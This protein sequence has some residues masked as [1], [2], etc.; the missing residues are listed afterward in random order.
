MTTTTLLIL[1]ASGDLTSR[2]LLPALGQLLA[3]EPQ[4]AITLLGAG[5]DDWSTEQWQQTVQSA[6]AQVD[7]EDALDRVSGKTY[8]QV[9]VTDPVSLRELFAGISSPY[10]LYFALPPAITRK[11]CELLT[12]ISLP[13]DTLL[14]L[15][16]PFGDDVESAQSL[17]QLLLTLVPEEQIFRVDHFLGRSTLLNVLGVRL[18]NR[19][20]AP[21]WNAE[22]VE[23][24]E[25]RFD[26]SLALEGRAWYYDHSGALV[27]MIQSHLLQVLSLVALEPP[28]SLDAV[29][30]RSAKLAAL[31]ATR[32]WQDDPAVASRRGRYTSGTVADRDIVSYVDEPGIDP[33]RNTETF[34]EVICEVQTERWAGV[35]FRLRSG[36]ALTTKRSEVSLLFRPVRHLA[37]G[38]SGSAPHGGRLTFALGPD[39]LQ[40]DLNMTGHADPFELRPGTLRADL[41]DGELLAY[42][43]VLA[44]FFDR[45]VTLSVSASA[46]EEGWRIIQPIRD[47]WTQGAVP[48]EDYPAGSEGPEPR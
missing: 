19:V 18:A 22:Q 7:A 31:R 44:E 38:F 14:A 1:G 24:V 17:N 42:S 33:S 3:R 25:I 45:D 35:P 43:E 5:A 16:K 29:S 9:D 34:A 32:I 11:C 23:S 26:E 12:T 37:D 21:I 30:V 36:K 28:A 27:D 39:E 2:L 6:F 4:R 41:G 8:T 40:L 15:E 10:T 46:A 20:F 48:L 47:A 13:E